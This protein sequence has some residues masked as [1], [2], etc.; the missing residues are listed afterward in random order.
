LAV[1][2]LCWIVA[3]VQ[4]SATSRPAPASLIE[5]VTVSEEALT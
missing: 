2:P 5:R 1:R 4:R 3:V